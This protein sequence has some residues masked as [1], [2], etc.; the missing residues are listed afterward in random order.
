MQHYSIYNIT[1]YSYGSSMTQC[2][3][4]GQVSGGASNWP[5]VQLGHAWAKSMQQS[6]QPGQPLGSLVAIGNSQWT[7]MGHWSWEM[8]LHCCWQT[9]H[10]SQPFLSTGVMGFSQSGC[11]QE[12]TGQGGSTSSQTKQPGQPTVTSILECLQLGGIGS[13]L[14]QGFIGHSGQSSHPLSLSLGVIGLSQ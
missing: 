13:H 6:V 5:E 1:N 2:S 7:C 11:R 3:Q 12:Y 9:G 8:G 4:V 14:G 10:P